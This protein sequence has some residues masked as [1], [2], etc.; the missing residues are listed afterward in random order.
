MG[1]FIFF[2][3]LIFFIF[4]F[5]SKAFGGS[6]KKKAKQWGQSDAEIRARQAQLHE[7]SQRL[8]HKYGHS[9]AKSN[10][11]NRMHNNDGSS[12]FPDSHQARVRARDKKD[13]IKN[14]Q[15]EKTL[16]SRQNF[17]ISKIKNKGR[18]DWG[19]RSEAGML[20]FRGILTMLG[21][22]LIAYIVVT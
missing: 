10:T 2:I 1:G 18:S 20:S 14:A 11:H 16:H 5:L 3:F 12:A 13:S 15:I 17:G 22:A 4:P 7:V 19:T 8:R 21:F 9:G 6:K